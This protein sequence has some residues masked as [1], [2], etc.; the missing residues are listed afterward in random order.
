MPLL[1]LVIPIFDILTHVLDDFIDDQ[2]KYPA[3]RA[4]ARRGRAMLNKYYGLLD[5][6]I[7]YCI[8]MRA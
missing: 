8:A 2:E 6:S 5:E 3:V 4:A 1:H 7:M